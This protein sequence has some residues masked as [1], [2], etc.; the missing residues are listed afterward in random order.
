VENL[1]GVASSR[2]RSIRDLSC[3]RASWVSAGA[4]AFVDGVGSGALLELRKS[5]D[6][7]WT[8]GVRAE[9]RVVRFDMVGDLLQ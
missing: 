6:V 7:V 9:L 4:R 3:A 8:A 5:G 1:Q 2:R